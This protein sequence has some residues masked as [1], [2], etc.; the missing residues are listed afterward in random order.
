MESFNDF[1]HS[2]VNAR[3]EGDEDPNSSLEAETMKLL[4]NSCY[5]YQIMDWNRCTVT[6]Y[7]SDKKRMEFSKR[8]S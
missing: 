8:K 6:K 1:F 5:G 7:L 4:A 2:A 3:R